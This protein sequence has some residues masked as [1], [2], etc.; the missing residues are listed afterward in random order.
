MSRLQTTGFDSVEDDSFD[1]VD[2]KKDDLIIEISLDIKERGRILGCQKNKLTIQIPK[3]PRGVYRKSTLY[4]F[5]QN[6]FSE[7]G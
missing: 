7:R 3:A 2:T 4:K 6:N 1:V 5:S